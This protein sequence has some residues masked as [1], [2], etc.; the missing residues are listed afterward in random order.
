MQT[1]ERWILG[2]SLALLNCFLSSAGLTLQRLSAKKD[3][4]KVC[5]PLWI[6]GV[7]L[8]ILAAVP[9]VF[10]YALIPEVIC[11]AIACFRMVVVSLMACLFL[12]ERFQAQQVAGMIACSIG[13]FVC[14]YFG[15]KR[16]DA[17][18]FKNA[19]LHAEITTYTIVASIVVVALFIF[20]HLDSISKTC[21]VPKRFRHITLPLLIGVTFAL[22]KVF[23]T[24]IGFLALPSKASF[25]PSWV[26]MSLVI[27]ACGLGDL[28][29]NLRAARLMDVQAFVPVAFAWCTTLQYFQSVVLF[30]ELKGLSSLCITLSLGGACVS[31]VGALLI[32]CPKL[33]PS[34]PSLIKPEDVPGSDGEFDVEH[35]RSKSG[36]SL[37]FL[38]PESAYS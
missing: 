11:S 8:Y 16:A 37:H 35:C 7:C 19:T 2:L 23:N 22:G 5:R 29:L 33:L 36:I 21:A 27:A 14:S 13:A 3:D 20:E 38:E 28:Y 31:L 34:R 17:A 26:A 9:D 10:S 12:D 32:M 24:E 15:P 1:F 25:D 6:F 30:D 4:E 18:A